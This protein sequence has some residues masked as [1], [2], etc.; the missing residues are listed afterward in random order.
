[1]GDDGIP[2][3]PTI[4]AVIIFGFPIYFIVLLLRYVGL[5]LLSN[6]GLYKKTIHFVPSEQKRINDE[7][8]KFRKKAKNKEKVMN[9]TIQ[10]LANYERLMEADENPKTSDQ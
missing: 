3:I 7:E 5:L 6:L 10:A 4:I 2:L 8:E 1:M 9:E